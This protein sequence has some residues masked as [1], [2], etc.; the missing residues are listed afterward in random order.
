MIK[1]Q[2]AVVGTTTQQFAGPEEPDTTEGA[3]DT[4]AS[5]GGV[6]KRPN[7]EGAMGSRGWGNAASRGPATSRHQTL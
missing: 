6:R 4:V 1:T 5:P 3:Q 7:R 2:A